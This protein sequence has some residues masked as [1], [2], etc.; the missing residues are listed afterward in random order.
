MG[1]LIAIT[2]AATVAFQETLIKKLRGENNFFLIWLRM[3]AALPVLAFLVTGFSSWAF[4]PRQFWLLIIGVNVPL[5][6]VQFYIGYTALQRAPISLLAPLASL[7]S[8]FLIP[9]GYGI[10]GELPTRIGLVG[11]VAIVLGTFAL[12]WRIGE[13]QSAAESVRNIFR[14]PASYLMLTSAFLVSISITTTK[15]VFQYAPPIL[16]AFYLTAAIGLAALLLSFRGSLR[17][18]EA[19]RRLSFLAG[20]GLTSG[21]S[22]GL[23]Y[24]GLSL[25]PAV[26]YIS[27]K[28]VSVLFNVLSGKFVFSETNIR[29]RFAGALLMVVGVILIALG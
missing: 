1:I 25:L 15:Y 28:R 23:H 18:G 9:V 26:Y 4:P 16:T 13:T 8:V 3:I 5:E 21:V 27:V 11:V 24:V 17:A 29:E 22:F 6:V 20:L 19:P 14:E 7:T 12:G 2:N 10:L